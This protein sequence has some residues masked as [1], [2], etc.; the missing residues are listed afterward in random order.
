MAK[1]TVNERRFPKEITD[2]DGIKDGEAKFYCIKW[3]PNE[4]CKIRAEKNEKKPSIPFIETSR[5]DG[6]ISNETK[7]YAAVKVY[8]G[9]KPKKEKEIKKTEIDEKSY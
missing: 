1:S 4:K 9:G 3:E 7:E 6:Q 5:R 2:T 8:P